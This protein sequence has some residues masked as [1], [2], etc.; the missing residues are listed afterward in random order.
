[1]SDL[2]AIVVD[3][4]FRARKALRNMLR[5][6]IPGVEVVGDAD[7]VDAAVALIGELRPDLVF[8]DIN[9]P[10]R[11]GFAL[12]EEHALPAIA[13]V[14]TTAYEQFAIRAMRADAVD[15]LIKPIDVDELQAAVERVRE[16]QKRRAAPPS[17]AEAP[18]ESPAV[19]AFRK[20]VIPTRDGYLLE[21][22]SRVLRAEASGS[23]TVF[24]FADGRQVVATRTLKVFEEQFQDQFFHRIHHKD[25]VNLHHIAE[26]NSRENYVRLSD[27]SVV[28]ISVRK[29][30]GLLRRLKE[31]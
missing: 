21:D 10:G 30:A 4:E 25:L 13:V 31:L 6:Y 8:L 23:Y 7:G 3:D 12:L 18:L 29:K 24:H 27:G 20:V 26:V 2:R 28:W 17:Q 15:Y 5:L 19:S 11:N 22:L 1:M 9:M 14:F 16:R